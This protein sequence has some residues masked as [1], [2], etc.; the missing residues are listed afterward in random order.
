LFNRQIYER[1]LLKAVTVM[2]L[3]IAFIFILVILL[4]FVEPFS[5]SQLIFDIMSAFG[6]VGLSL[7]ITEDLTTFSK[8]LLMFLMFVERIG[9][10]TFLYTFRKESQYDDSF[11]YPNERIIIG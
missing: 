5:L 3:A 4:L 1:D 8:L 6:S 10:V 7:G 2:I 9:V 11:R